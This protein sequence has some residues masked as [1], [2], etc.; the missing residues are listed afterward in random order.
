MLPI[1]SHSW[2]TLF[3]NYF[4][5][6]RS[7]TRNSLGSENRESKKRGD[8]SKFQKP[9][10]KFSFDLE[11]GIVFY[12]GKPTTKWTDAAILQRFEIKLL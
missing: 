11:P 7:E 4:I 1:E 9:N 12:L 8:K 10:E 5:S 6:E 2:L 3:Y